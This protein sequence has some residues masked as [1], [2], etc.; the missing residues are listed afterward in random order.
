MYLHKK[1]SN[2]SQNI[3]SLTLRILTVTKEKLLN[4]LLSRHQT[5]GFLKSGTRK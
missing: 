1:T 5:N 4:S 2:K 3:N